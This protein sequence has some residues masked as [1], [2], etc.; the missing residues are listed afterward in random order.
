MSV[1]HHRTVVWSA[2]FWW[3]MSPWTIVCS[4]PLQ[5]R[6]WVPYIQV[7]RKKFFLQLTCLLVFFVR[8]CCRFDSR[9]Y[10]FHRFPPPPSTNIVVLKTQRILTLHFSRTNTNLGTFFL[11]SFVF[12]LVNFYLSEKILEER[13]N[14]YELF[15]VLFWQMGKC[16]MDRR[17]SGRK[18][19]WL[20]TACRY[21]GAMVTIVDW[22]R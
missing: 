3:R 20:M 1:I 7:S 15:S 12:Q 9:I 8:K 22:R 18:T 4:L 10:F 19:W 16:V 14:F 13:S 2:I 21:W 6:C 11:F 17:F 5:Q